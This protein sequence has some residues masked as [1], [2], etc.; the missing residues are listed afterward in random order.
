MTRIAI[1]GTSVLVCLSWQTVVCCQVKP[2]FIGEAAKEYV[3]QKAAA[4]AEARKAIV[5]CSG[6]LKKSLD[7]SIAKEEGRLAA[8][9]AA[10]IVYG[11]NAA[12]RRLGRVDDDDP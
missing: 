10:K 12:E 1:I 6:Q 3:R 4:L 7:A 9:R 2:D 5:S 11:D 8:I